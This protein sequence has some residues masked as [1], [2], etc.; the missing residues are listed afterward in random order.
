[1]GNFTDIL[2]EQAG[3]VANQVIGQA[4]GMAF[5]AYND[6]RQRKQQRNLQEIQL[7]GNEKALEQQRVKEMKKWEDTNYSAQV[8][9]LKKA[10]LNAGLIY[11]MSGGG[12]TTTGGAGAGVTGASA[13][14]RMV[15]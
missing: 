1:M 14:E 4:L 15:S 11:G 13:P 5:G 6:A 7:Q 3:G 8:E 10:G 12:G 2:A 9:Q